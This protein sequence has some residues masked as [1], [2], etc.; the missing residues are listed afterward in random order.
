M[1]RVKKVVECLPN[2]AL[3][4]ARMSGPNGRYCLAM[5]WR[6]GRTEYITWRLDIYGAVESTEDGHYY[7]CIVAAAQDLAFRAGAGAKKVMA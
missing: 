3:E 5:W 2:G 4:I 6:N 1:E 7:A